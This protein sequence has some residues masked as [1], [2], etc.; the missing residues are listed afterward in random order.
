MAS[1][2]G[3]SDPYRLLN[4][5]LDVR[6][7]QP[8][9]GRDILAK[10]DYD[11]LS[12]DGLQR[13]DAVL[14]A[15]ERVGA[16]R[17]EYVRS[18]RPEEGIKNVRLLDATRL[19][20]HLGRSPAASEAERA[21]APL[22]ALVDGRPAYIRQV[23]RDLFDAWVRRTRAHQIDYCDT[24]T[25]RTFLGLLCGFDDNLHDGVDEKTFCARAV[26]DSKAIRQGGH[27]SRL[28]R[29]L[30]PVH[31]VTGTP[32]AVLETL[33]I[34]KFPTPLCFRGP[35]VCAG[36]AMDGFHPYAAIPPDA[37]D[38]VRPSQT[39][40]YVLS[41]ENFASFNRYVR[42]TGDGGL[43]VYAA[44]YPSRATITFLQRLDDALA[45]DVAFFHWGDIE[46]GGLQAFRVIESALK[47]PL[48]P[49][50]MDIESA[51]DLGSPTDNKPRLRSLAE[52]DSAIAPLAEW[53]AR[54][55]NPHLLEQEM[56]DPI[57]P[58]RF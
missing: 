14:A 10:I 35:V 22:F 57:S 6:E 54:G 55:E 40:R 32:E 33:G 17:R 26:R 34:R 43:I 52:S 7:Q 51:I 38:S 50:A 18:R 42:E 3:F 36:V 21:A 5:M 53:L 20:A 2:T 31:G 39:P 30:G 29:V 4:W 19:Y 16:V 15:A 8:E 56:L 28:A 23:A 45:R 37:V 25:A 13:F 48:S 41:I 1:R 24:A 11:A 58:L 9:R 49:H 47:R 27:A 12:Y 44:G 46:E